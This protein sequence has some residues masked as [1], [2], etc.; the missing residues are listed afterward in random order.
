MA[1]SVTPLS[2]SPY[3]AP[4]RSRALAIGN[5]RLSSPRR[6]QDAKN[7]VRR[8]TGEG[9]ID[10]MTGRGKAAPWRSWTVLVATLS[11][12]VIGCSNGVQDVQTTTGATAIDSTVVTTTTPP[13]TTTTTAPE[14]AGDEW[15]VGPLPAM[16][17]ER[18]HYADVL[19][20][21]YTEWF[22]GMN[23]RGER[24]A[25][26]A[27]ADVSF[28]PPPP[29]TEEDFPAP[30]AP[31]DDIAEIEVQYIG[32]P[33]PNSQPDTSPAWITGQAIARTVD[34]DSAARVMDAVRECSE[35]AHPL[36][37]VEGSAADDE[38]A[39]LLSGMG[40]DDV[41]TASSSGEPMVRSATF[42]VGPVVGYVAVLGNSQIVPDVDVVES[43]A[44]DLLSGVLVGV[45]PLAD[46]DTPAGDPLA[47]FRVHVG[48]RAIGDG[49]PDEVVFEVP[50]D[51]A[52]AS[53]G[54]VAPDG[55]TVAFVWYDPEVEWDSPRDR[56]T[57]LSIAQADGTIVDVVTT[58]Q[59]ERSTGTQWAR[60]GDLAWNSDGSWLAF[61]WQ[62]PSAWGEVWAVRPDGSDL[63][64]ATPPSSQ[65]WY[66]GDEE[67]RWGP[68]PE[69]LYFQSAR[70]RQGSIWR[71]SMDG[72]M[73]EQVT[74]DIEDSQISNAA[75]SPDGRWLVAVNLRNVPIVVDL[76]TGDYE[77]HDPVPEIENL[78]FAW[79]QWSPDGRVVYSFAGGGTGQPIQQ[80]LLVDPAAG[81]IERIA[82]PPNR[83]GTLVWSDDGTRLLTA[84]QER[85]TDMVGLA[86]I[87]VETGE[88]TPVRQDLGEVSLLQPTWP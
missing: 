76:E 62:E 16:L 34:V 88:V 77:L 48:F 32:Q 27:E 12:S 11:M 35:V 6:M 7:G 38:L 68:D 78:S 44:R 63:R 47:G 66:D 86:V 52:L 56:Q 39:D 73:M 19:F 26:A 2:D 57:T 8:N 45:R 15:E 65:E 85:F 81:T 55:K 42:R 23:H 1:P 31:R 64:L 14:P 69:I 29:L 22:Q 3:G 75:I 74:P 37:P 61:E 10:S 36:G 80:A 25:V 67:P 60:I 9:R 51:R 5:H 54:A 43:H 24:E 72:S 20:L 49:Q 17:I 58:E 46:G 18:Q 28:P 70:T 21:T 53:R 87:D 41:V 30:C 33:I 84:L 13:S 40:A 50:P 82:V 71:T 83:G 59:I 4:L 79:P